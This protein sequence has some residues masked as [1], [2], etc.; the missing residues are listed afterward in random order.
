ME[1]KHVMGSVKDIEIIEAPEKN[2][3]GLGRF[4]FSDRYSVFDWGE[5]P[6]HISNKGASL[7]IISAYFFEKLGEKHRTHYVGVVENGKVKR[8]DEL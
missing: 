6:D 1:V 4:V 7:C 2:R 5:M 8:L 3:L